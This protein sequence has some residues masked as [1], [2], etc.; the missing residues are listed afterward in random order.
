METPFALRP[1]KCSLNTDTLPVNNHHHRGGMS[2]I[3]NKFQSIV[4]NL[5]RIGSGFLCMQHGAQTVFGLL[6]GEPAE[7]AELYSLIGLAAIVE[8]AG[9]LAILFGF[10]TQAIALLMLVE[11]ALVYFL[12]YLPQGF[13]LTPGQGELAALYAFVFL[14]LAVNGGGNFSLDALMEK[15]K[16]EESNRA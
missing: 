5:L 1:W 12:V 3:K 8:L 9:G 7:T 16:E 15:S 2:T 4:L 11:M 10:L 14:F 6:F 13:W